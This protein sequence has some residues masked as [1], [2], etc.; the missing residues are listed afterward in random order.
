M[1]SDMYFFILDCWISRYY[2][3]FLTENKMELPFELIYEIVIKLKDAYEILV[4]LNKKIRDN[5]YNLTLNLDLFG[6]EKTKK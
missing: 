2:P 3:S 1:W 5:T 6:S 4:L